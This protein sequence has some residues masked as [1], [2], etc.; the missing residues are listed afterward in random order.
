MNC[1]D[2]S[3]GPSDGSLR[4][5]SL[6]D[7]WNIKQSQGAIVGASSLSILAGISSGPQALLG[8]S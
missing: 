8:F 2:Q 5:P 6:Y 3:F 4:V 7:L 1:T